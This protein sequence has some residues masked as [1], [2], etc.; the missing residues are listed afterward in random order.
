MKVAFVLAS[1]CLVLVTA[2]PLVKEPA[3]SACTIDT[4]C[5]K[6][7]YDVTDLKISFS[8]DPPEKG[9]NVTI[10]A[11]GTVNKEIT[12]G[13]IKVVAKYGIIT[14]LDQSYDVCDLVQQIGKQCPIPA[15]PL[16][17]SATTM[18]PSDVPPGKYHADIE[19]TDQD[20]K[21]MICLMAECQL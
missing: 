8:P 7:N 20:G 11:S 4:S 2:S 18:V 19:G 17:G 13:K 21:P 6:S 5:D 3:A 16:S 1:F 10:T 9:K 14:V 12:G 15:G